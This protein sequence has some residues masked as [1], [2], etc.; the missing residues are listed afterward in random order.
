MQLL[1]SSLACQY[2]QDESL[3]RNELSS[4][5]NARIFKNT[6]EPEEP[7]YVLMEF[8]GP[9]RKLLFELRGDETQRLY[10]HLRGR[11]VMS[12]FHERYQAVKK[13]GKGNQASVRAIEWKKII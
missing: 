11:V 12:N 6:P 9:S 10:K 1:D 13:I 2:H 7:K 4:Q 5:S 8:P 3:Q